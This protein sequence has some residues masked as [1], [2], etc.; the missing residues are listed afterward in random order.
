[1]TRAKV[2]RVRSR[3][4]S[5]DQWVIIR[6][7]GHLFGVGVESS[8]RTHRLRLRPDRPVWGGWT[9]YDNDMGHGFTWRRVS[10]R[11]AL[12]AILVLTNKESP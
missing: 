6:R 10:F 3:A 8:E 5:P 4:E 11:K 12:A 1:M 9:K 7:S 2:H